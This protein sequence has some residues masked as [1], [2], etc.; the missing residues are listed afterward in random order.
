MRCDKCVHLLSLDPFRRSRGQASQHLSEH[1]AH[2][3]WWSGCTKSIAPQ[4]RAPSNASVPASADFDT[5]KPPVR[6]DLRGDSK[7]RGCGALWEPSSCARRAQVPLPRVLVVQ[8][9]PEST[10]SIGAQG[11]FA[12]EDNTRFGRSVGRSGGASAPAFVPAGRAGLLAAICFWLRSPRKNVAAMVVAGRLSHKLH[13]R[14][15]KHA[16]A[17][18]AAGVVVGIRNSFAQSK[19]HT[20]PTL[21]RN[22][23][24]DTC[25]GCAARLIDRLIDRGIV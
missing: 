10:G 2:T 1:Q 19:Q 9:S 11:P 15:R 7:Q 6:G 23:A 4:K 13:S 14:Q 22:T 12:W 25:C 20:R 16:A 3:L 21:G 8:L 5:Q 17:A 18:G 24:F